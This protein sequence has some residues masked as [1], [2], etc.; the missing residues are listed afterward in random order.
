MSHRANRLLLGLGIAVVVAAYV[1]RVG[2]H[3]IDFEVGY[4][5]GNRLLA[6]ES[7]YRA[8]DGHFA[9][10]YLPGAALLQMPFSLPPPAAAK[11]LFY[12]FSVGCLVAAL[13]LAYDLLPE[14][15]G[16]RPA[17]AVW[18][19]V[20]LAKYLLRE[21]HLGQINLIILVLLLLSLKWHLP[22]PEGRTAARDAAAGACWALATMLKPYGLVFV[23]YLVLTGRFRALAAGL[24]CS[25]LV[26]AATLLFYTP[27]EMIQAHVDWWRSL[28]VSTPP[29]LLNEDN[30]SLLAFFTRWLG[31]GSVARLAALAA[32]AGAALL[33]LLVTLRGRG[34]P[35]AV[36]LDGA[37]LTTLIPL[38]APL[39][40]N[41]TLLMSLGAV[42]LL[43]RRRDR[44]GPLA[45][46][47]L[48]ADLVTIAL[49]TSSVIG[50]TLHAAFE[51]RSIP[52]IQFAVL[53]GYL[54]ALRF[55]R[56]D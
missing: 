31:P 11:A 30:I 34:Q 28:S 13:Y 2:G 14:G 19:F 24:A 32:V 4:V 17:L 42:M 52:T 37:I 49:A 22:G 41:Y 51:A 8:S 29:L 12:L 10:K 39:G 40:W 9:Y 55:T 38:L 25:G 47:V 36:V 16:R 43:L 15:P 6:G 48:L 27:A 56:V 35:R 44:F 3:M 33:V 26:T 1:F 46:G 53:I 54:A 21:I 50:G 45:R 7:L 20:I 5:A 23:P 18:T